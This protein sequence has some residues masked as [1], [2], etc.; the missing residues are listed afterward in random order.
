MLVVL[1]KFAE[2]SETETVSRCLKFNVILLCVLNH[3][4]DKSPG[5]AG[6]FEEEAFFAAMR[7][8]SLSLALKSGSERRLRSK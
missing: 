3:S 6:P 8:L 1:Y 5:R 4:I 2:N 7:R